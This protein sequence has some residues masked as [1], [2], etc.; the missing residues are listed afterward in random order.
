MRKFVFLTL[1]G[2]AFLT[3]SFV[4]A[5]A[6]EQKAIG[7]YGEWS[8]Y[9]LNEEGGGKVCYMASQ[10][11]QKKGNYTRRG[12]VFALVTHR[13]KEG[14]KNVFS[15]YTGYSYKVGS[16]AK[17]NIDGKRFTLFT[18]EETAWALDDM[19]DKLVEAI[20][21][22]SKMVVTGVSSRGTNTTDTF[23]LKGSSAAHDAIS[24]ECNM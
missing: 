2:M 8:V 12:E 22:G 17:I 19:D 1:M 18:N 11:Q 21:A 15:Y 10:P 3:L 6:A 20:R 14:T 24:K 7:T 9:V 13:T 5:E 4:G 23:S 16:D